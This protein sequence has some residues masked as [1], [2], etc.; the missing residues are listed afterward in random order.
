MILAKMSEAERSSK[1]PNVPGQTAEP[2]QLKFTYSTDA[3]DSYM[4]EGLTPPDAWKRPDKFELAFLSQVDLSKGKIKVSNQ[5]VSIK[6][7]R[8]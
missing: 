3:Y 7:T 5:D 6:S 8:L 4:K 2:Q 1:K